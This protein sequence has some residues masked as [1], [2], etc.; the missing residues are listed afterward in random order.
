MSTYPLI[1][2]HGLIGDRQTA[3]LIGTDGCVDWFCAPRFDSPSIDEAVSRRRT[4]VPAPDAGATA[5]AV[6]P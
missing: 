5:S 3:A 2:G 6:A 1:A 4:V